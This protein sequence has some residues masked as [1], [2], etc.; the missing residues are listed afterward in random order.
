MLNNLTSQ[1]D[2]EDAKKDIELTELRE[3]KKK[4]KIKKTNLKQ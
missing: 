1:K 2:K 3:E 4:S